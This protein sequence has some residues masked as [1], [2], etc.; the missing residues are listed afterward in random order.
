MPVSRVL[1]EMSWQEILYWAAHFKIE[2]DRYEEERL[3]SRA[4]SNIQ[5]TKTWR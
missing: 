4:T 3:A 5:Q 1:A 2:H